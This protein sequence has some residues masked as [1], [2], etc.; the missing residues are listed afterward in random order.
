M[1]LSKLISTEKYYFMKFPPKNKFNINRQKMFWDSIFHAEGF[2]EENNFDILYTTDFTFECKHILRAICKFSTC[3][4][5]Q[6]N[7]Q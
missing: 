7:K 3:H 2:L 1:H 4:I 6:K 5:A